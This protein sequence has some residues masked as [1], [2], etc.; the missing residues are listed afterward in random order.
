MANKIAIVIPARFGSTRLPGKPLKLIAGKEML[1]RVAMIAKSVCDNRTDC[2]YIVATD[3]SRIVDFCGT[4]NVPVAM[5]AETCQSG[6]ERSW[7]ALGALDFTP[8]LIVNLQGDNPLCPPWFIE[9]LITAWERDPHAQV[10]TPYIQLSWDELDR[11]REAK[12]VTPFSGTTVVVDKESYALAFSKNIIPAIRKEKSLRSKM[13]QSPAKRHIGLYAY[14]YSALK[15]YF[16]LPVSPYEEFEGLEQMRFL[17][18]N[19]PVK[20]VQVDYRGY[21]SMSGVD[22]PEDILRAEAMI[23]KYGEFP[24]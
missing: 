14:T 18:N 6:T 12:K 21:G 15:E 24:L 17:H 11:L 19:V 23:E 16:T 20:M 1:S 10:L 2:T 13:A 4:N 5:T 3:D 22:S 9:E 8:E 7:D